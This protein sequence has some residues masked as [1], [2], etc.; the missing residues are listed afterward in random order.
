MCRGFYSPPKW[1]SSGTVCFYLSNSCS[2]KTVLYVSIF[3]SR[4]TFSLFYKQEKQVNAYV[5]LLYLYGSYYCCPLIIEHN[6]VDLYVNIGCYTSH[7]C[8]NSYQKRPRA[9]QIRNLRERVP[10]L[11]H[12]GRRTYD[13]PTTTLKCQYYSQRCHSQF[14][15]RAYMLD[16]VADDDDGYSSFMLIVHANQYYSIDSSSFFLPSGNYTV[17][18]F[19]LS[20]VNS[21]LLVS[22]AW[23][24]IALTMLNGVAQTTLRSLYDH[25]QITAYSSCRSCCYGQF[26]AQ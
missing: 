8:H 16:C 14:L 13:R 7:A 20:C 6:S 25:Q 15:Y 4:E 23:L 2:E 22:L 26:W 1:F 5:A 19:S 3:F 24:V 17:Y 11:W 12:T 21:L 18:L 10:R 9:S